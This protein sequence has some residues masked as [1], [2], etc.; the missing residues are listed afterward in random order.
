MDSHIFVEILLVLLKITYLITSILLIIYGSNCY[1]YVFLFLKHRKKRREADEHF[2]KAFYER[3][4]EKDFP[5]VTTQ[6]PIFNE[7]YVALRLIDAVVAMDYPR[8]KHEVQVLDDSLDDTWDIVEAHIRPLIEQ[9]HDIKHIRRSDRRDF[10]AGALQ[11]G[12]ATARGEFVS[13]FDSDFVPPPEFLKK[14]VPYLVEQP[15]VG[16]VQT[17][18]GHLNRSESLLTRAQAIGID[19][20]F[21][22]EQ[23]ARQ[24][25]NLYLNF[26]GTAGIWR[27]AAINGSGGWQG[28]TLT[29]DLDL[30][31]RAQLAGWKTEFLFDVECRA[32][33]PAD[34]N[35]FKAQQFRW[36]KGSIQVAK[37][38]LT[39]LYR[40]PLSPWKKA[41]A[42]VHLT[43]Y[44]IH[45]LIVINALISLPMI[46]FTEQIKFSM[47][48]VLV[49]MLLSLATFAPTFMYVVSQWGRGAG[50]MRRLWEIPFL[51]V[52]GIGIGV[53][54][55]WAV[56]SALFGGKGVFIRTPKTGS[57]VDTGVAKRKAQSKGYKLKWNWVIA[58][59]LAL[60]SYC[61]Y[62]FAYFLNHEAVPGGSILVAPF[63][64]LYGVAFMSAF[65]LSIRH[66][67]Q[68][69]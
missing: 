41:Q 18:W 59:E 22:I 45:P 53:N 46:M 48:Y 54:N 57:Q 32:E 1:T 65:L 2:L 4:R 56:I 14:T 34:M 23:S 55:S 52:V 30:S 12:L 67:V 37:K 36:A 11:A 42:T 39:T 16:F 51:A 9:G 8:E 38:L 35:A 43:H 40:S 7:K 47:Y 31:Y 63:L 50:W 19:G 27:K 62:A 60:A 20:H 66:S 17:R 6:L 24:W 10:K 28:D 21:V 26:N 49:V 25:S 64:L 3:H 61:L 29:E 44:S 15:K 58:V 68:R 33:I 5:P 69:S 13:I